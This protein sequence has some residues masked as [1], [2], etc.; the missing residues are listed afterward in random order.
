M[1]RTIT[2]IITA[3][4]CTVVGLW[5]GSRYAP[6]LHGLFHGTGMR[7]EPMSA[8]QGG[9]APDEVKRLYTCG[10]HPQV[11]QDHPGD[12]PICGMKLVPMKGDTAAPAS[13]PEGGEKAEGERRIK[14]WVAPMDPTYIRDSPG[15]SPMGMDLVPVYED[16]EPA[17]DEHPKAIRIDPT[18]VQNMGVRTAPVTRRDLT[19][20]LRTNG[21]VTEDETRLTE[22]NTKVGGWIERL[23]VAETGQQVKKGDPLLTLYAPDLV[24]TQRE[25]LLAMENLRKV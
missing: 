18:V 19:R 9:G 23:F 4:T 6:Q 24:T 22:I 16:E 15:K 17:A 21:H 20:S 12:C 13:R 1:K 10:M 8:A 3:I 2:L 5:A 11:I 14:Y 25:Y 7:D